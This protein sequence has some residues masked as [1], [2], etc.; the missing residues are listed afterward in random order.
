MKLQKIFISSVLKLMLTHVVSRIA[1][2]SD[3]LLQWKARQKFSS[4]VVLGRPKTDIN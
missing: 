4:V 1:V 3:C 2:W